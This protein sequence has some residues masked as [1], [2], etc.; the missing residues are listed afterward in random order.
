MLS[1]VAGVVIISLAVLFAIRGWRGSQSGPEQAIPRQR[2]VT[3]NPT[4]NPVY[5]AA[6]SPDGRYVAY[7]DY[8][9][10]FVRLLE[11]GE[12]HSLPLPEGFCFK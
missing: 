6:I 7:A 11:S 8:T 10:V 5:A 3:T 4:E 12:T 1:I 2:S 9:G